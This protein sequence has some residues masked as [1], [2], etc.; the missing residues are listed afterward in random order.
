MRRLVF[1]IALVVLSAAPARAQNCVTIN[2]ASV[3]TAAT[4]APA[5]SVRQRGSGYAFC[6]QSAITAENLWC[7]DKLGG[8]GIASTMTVSGSSSFG[9]STSGSSF[10]FGRLAPTGAGPSNTGSVVFGGSGVSTGSTVFDSYTIFELTHRSGMVDGNNQQTNEVD[11]VVSSSVNTGSA[12]KQKIAAI[13][14][15]LEGTTAHDRGGE[16][17][18]DT[19]VDG[20][21]LANAL[22]VDNTQRVQIGSTGL[23]ATPSLVNVA[24][25]TTG[26][27]WDASP[28]LYM[29]VNGGTRAAFR[30]ASTHVLQNTTIGSNT[31]VAH[32][33][34]ELIGSSGVVFNGNT[35]SQVN[36][37][38]GPNITTNGTLQIIP[39]TGNG[40]FTFSTAVIEIASTG[41]TT[42]LSTVQSPGFYS[43]SA[44]VLFKGTGTGATQVASTQTTPP[45]CTTNCGSSVPA[46]VGTDSDMI[47]TLGTTP[48]SGFVVVFNGTWAAAPSCVGQMAKTG[49]A[50]GKQPLTLVTTT[51]QI[52]VVTNGVAPASGD[53]YAIQCRGVQ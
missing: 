17:R 45:T 51:G 19:K 46:Q 6:V 42:F 32:A 33:T 40:G 44:K 4:T 41:A 53:V 34:L 3:C 47:I 24:A 1:V 9:T 28:A 27:Y 38:L 26:L 12:T 20:G 10:Q 52:T 31:A 22:T 29:S 23:A 49:M 14:T 30:D 15:Y 43:P 2:G 16:W 36:W 21:V 8:L 48:A 7:V 11:W 37:E 39:S 13:E 18:L 5:M 50:V 25:L 35:G